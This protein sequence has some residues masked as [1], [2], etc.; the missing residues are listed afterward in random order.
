MR[1]PV[2]AA[3]RP[4]AA[5]PGPAV[6]LASSLAHADTIAPVTW[7]QGTGP[8]KKDRGGR[9]AGSRPRRRPHSGCNAPGRSPL[10]AR[11]PLAELCGCRRAD[12]HDTTAGLGLGTSRA[13][14]FTGAAPP[15]HP[16]RPRQPCSRAAGML[17]LTHSSP[18]TTGTPGEQNIVPYPTA[19]LA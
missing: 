7:R 15:R 10:L 17:D 16:R 12:Q 14:Q 5:Y 3:R 2:A 19:R 6:N 1:A 13:A 11:T 9:A 4:P 18:P 8:P